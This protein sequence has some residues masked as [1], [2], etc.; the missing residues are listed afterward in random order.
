[1]QR[2]PPAPSD[3]SPAAGF[4]RQPV[5]LLPIIGRFSATVATVAILV[6]FGVPLVGCSAT[7]PYDIDLEDR[8]ARTCVL[9]CRNDKRDC[10]GAMARAFQD[11]L[12]RHP[13]QTNRQYHCYE[14]RQQEILASLEMPL[15]GTT[16]AARYEDCLVRACGGTAPGHE[17]VDQKRNSTTDASDPSTG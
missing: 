5:A 3:A 1:M 12:S 8:D 17:A 10:D 7:G 16:C 15:S 13:G 11:C 9:R 14:K 4:P 2:V 6:S